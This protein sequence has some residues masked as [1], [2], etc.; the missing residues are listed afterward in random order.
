MTHQIDIKTLINN[1]FAGSK[2][3]VKAYFEQPYKTTLSQIVILRDS[4]NPKLPI[5]YICGCF[6][7]NEIELIINI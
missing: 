1:K 7:D 2:S 5:S 3:S 6:L 4:I